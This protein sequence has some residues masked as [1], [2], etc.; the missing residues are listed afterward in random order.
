MPW[1]GDRARCGPPDCRIPDAGA[2]EPAADRRARDCATHALAAV[3][4]HEQDA[5]P[6]VARGPD[7]HRRRHQ[8]RDKRLP[9]LPVTA[10]SDPLTPA[11]CSSFRPKIHSRSDRRL[12]YGRIDGLHRRRPTRRA[13]RRLAR[14]A[15]RSCAPRRTR[16]RPS[17]SPGTDQSDS[18]A[19][20]GLEAMHLV[21]EALHHLD[22]DRHLGLRTLGRRGERRADLEQLPLDALGERAISASS[23][24]DRA[25]PS[26]EFSS[27][28]LPYAS[29]RS[30]AFE[31]RMPPARPVCPPSPSVVEMLLDGWPCLSSTT[32]RQTDDGNK[33]C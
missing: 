26:V 31:T 7:R 20:D 1:V 27:S 30:D 33:A 15:G 6:D 22:L 17:M 32:W 23:Q 12:R 18:H 11:S 10:R 21:R 4:T 2:R 9:V 16:R 29:T 3:T 13:G 5:E 19:V 14:H 24:I 8:A 25:K 28:T